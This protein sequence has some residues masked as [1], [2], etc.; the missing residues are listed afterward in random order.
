MLLRLLYP[1]AAA[2]SSGVSVWSLVRRSRRSPGLSFSEPTS[3]SRLSGIQAYDPSMSQDAAHG[4]STADELA[5]LADLRDRGVISEADFQ[6]GKDKI[7]R[8]AA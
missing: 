1:T 2:R 5:K 4:T 3:S 6:Q 7:L 8:A